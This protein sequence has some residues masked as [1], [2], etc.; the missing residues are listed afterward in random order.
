MIRNLNI[1]LFLILE[2]VALYLLSTGTS[3]HNIKISNA[4]RSAEAYLQ[5]NITEATSYFSLREI[6]EQLEYENSLLRN[7]LERSYRDED[8]DFFEVND[9]VYFQQYLYTRA[10]VVNISINKQKNFITLNKG[11]MHGVNEGMA[12]T[13]PEGIAGVVV[14]AGK[15]F[16]VAMS[17]L[18]LDFRL[19]ARLRKNDYFGSLN[20]DGH[21][22]R[23]V[24]LNEIP[25]HVN[26]S[27]GDTI[28]TTGFSSVFPEG[29]LIGTIYEFDGSGG[30]FYSVKVRLSTDFQKLTSAYIVVNLKKKEQLS[31]EDTLDIQN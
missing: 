1:I 15:N 24:L 28:E 6:N 8:I 4:A 20:W 30:D 2:G 13:G 14:Q 19:S 9:S 17:V 18:N 23:T 10:K 12:L 7:Q 31:L 22:T 25:H 26:L 11:T 29:I 3:Y 5:R 27:I 21:D 16:S